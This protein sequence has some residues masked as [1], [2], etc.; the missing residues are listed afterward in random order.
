MGDKKS[1]KNIEPVTLFIFG[2][3]GIILSAIIL[4]FIEI[5][6][7]FVLYLV[8]SI[9]IISLVLFILGCIGL[10]VNTQKQKAKVNEEKTKV[11]LNMNEFQQ[12]YDKYINKL[13]IVERKTQVTLIELNEY[14]YHS[15]IPQY[16]W[17]E[18]DC[19]NMFPMSQYYKQSC[20][21][22]VSKPDVS[23][24]HLKTIPIDKILYFEEIGELRKYTT[25]SGGGSSLKGALLGY[26]LA[27]D[28]GALI[29]SRKPIETKIVSED[30]R[31]IEL[32]YKNDK[33]EIVNLEFTHDAYEVFKKVIPLKELRRIA[34]LNISNNTGDITDIKESITIKEKLKQLNDLKTEGLITD[35]EYSVQ[36]RKILDTL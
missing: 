34:G 29:G 35:E 28:I 8:S 4:P 19:F 22:S 23:M 10:E 17:I 12:D 36:K 14:D 32:I 21:S 20:T 6:S 25:V 24:L 5:N 11:I 9:P 2:I 7:D 1:K 16:L 3:V 18:N 30:D 13:G 27:D 26:V 31:K 33:N 15:F